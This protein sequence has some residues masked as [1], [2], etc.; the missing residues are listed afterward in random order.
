MKNFIIF[1]FIYL[2][3]FSLFSQIV[4]D[5]PDQTESAIVLVNGNFQ[6]ESGF[7][8]E[9]KKLESEENLTILNNLFRIGILKGLEFRVNTNIIT[10]LNDSSESKKVF[11]SDLEIGTKIQILNK[12]SKNTKI[13]F[14]T[15]YIV[16]SSL[17]GTSESS[18]LINRLLISHDISQDY[19]LSYNIGYNKYF[20]F[21]YDEIIYTIS[22][23]RSFKKFGIYFEIFGIESINISK[24]NWDTGVTYEVNNNL[25]I[26]FAK[27]KGFNNDLN[28]ITL[29]ICWLFS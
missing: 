10:E 29:G 6:I 5:R 18:G 17:I 3:S 16:P 2:V 8:F 28:Y 23:A 22:F 27:V 20:N 1:L 26:D 7:I 15:H 25:Q 4:S 13:A 9:N 12:Q 19:Q 11:F 24:F 21:N 14:L